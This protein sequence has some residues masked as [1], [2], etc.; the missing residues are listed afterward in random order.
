MQSNKKY[1]KNRNGDYL[2][3][4]IAFISYYYLFILWTLEQYE[5]L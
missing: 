5:V 3:I 4:W 2:E 1:V